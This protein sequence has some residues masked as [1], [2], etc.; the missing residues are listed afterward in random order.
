[1]SFDAGLVSA[2][3]WELNSR[4][5]GA[6]VEK[7]LQPERDEIVFMLHSGHENLRLVL[8]SGTNN[9]R[10]HL[11]QRVKENPMVAPMFCMLLRKHL[12]GAKITSIIQLGFERAVEFGFDCFDEMGFRV[13]KYIVTETMGKYSNIILLG[14]DKKV[15]SAMKIIDLASS[16]VR[17]ILPGFP[18]EL[19]PAQ[20]KLSPLEVTREEFFALVRQ[21]EDMPSDKFIMSN[22][23]G[24]SPL[25]A[26]E[27]VFSAIG[28]TDCPLS[29]CKTDKLWRGFVSVFDHIKSC[30][31]EPWLVMDKSG[32]PSEYCFF[33]PQEYERT[34]ELKKCGSFSELLDEFFV[35]RDRAERIKQRTSDIFRT[36]SNIEN[37]LKKKIAIQKKDLEDSAE[38][39]KFRLWGDLITANIYRLARGDEAAVLDNYYEADCPKITVKLDS[40]LT[41]VQN[42]Q[43]Y[44]KKYNKSKTAE[45]ELSKQ[46]RLAEAELDYIYTVFDSLTHAETENDIAEIKDELY[47]SGYGSRMKNYQAKKL[48]A[49][50][51]MEFVSTGGRRI[52]CGK[53]NHQ[54]DY[55]TTKLASKTDYWFHVR[56]IPGSHCI[57]FCDG[58]E[59]SERD[60]TEAATIAAYYSKANGGENIPVDYTLIKNVHKPS[61]AKPGFVTYSTNFTAYVTP[62]ESTVE[63]LKKKK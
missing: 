56:N 51:P 60:F 26:R 45:V 17:Q 11:T 3:V 44:Y 54:N 15:I 30:T 46:I 28:S 7:V 32:H 50:K 2:V 18:Y 35:K 58:D 43:K 42:A 52:V 34:C 8:S 1:M 57:L 38:K 49:P 48:A 25:V 37:R 63:R 14:P 40:K 12:T 21:S 27:T 29:E 19:P 33:K 24:I 5:I 23:Y 41:P 10:F 31:Y 55:V 36:L 9:P 4:I 61:G 53:N 62:D 6:R 22:F 39:E 13:T 47:K 20:R 59:P 16:S